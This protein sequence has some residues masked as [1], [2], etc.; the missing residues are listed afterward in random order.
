[1]KRIAIVLAVLLG[2]A[3]PASAA[4]PASGGEIEL[5]IE[6]VGEAQPR[7][8]SVVFEIQ[9]TG[10]SPAAAERGLAAAKADLTRKFG[11][12]GIKSQQITFNDMNPDLYPPP[13]ATV[14]IAPP[15]PPPAVA[16]ST[17]PD[18]VQPVAVAVA[19]PPPVIR[20][21]PP[22]PKLKDS[23]RST[24]TIALDDLGKLDAV[25]TKARDVSRTSYRAPTVIYAQ[26]DPAEA[27]DEAVNKAIS[28]ARAEADRYA[29]AMGYR[30]VRIARVSN[31]KP[32]LNMPDL[33]QFIGTLDRRTGD[34]ERIF[35]TVWAG[36]AIDFVIAPK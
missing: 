2:T 16:A 35:A 10:E 17:K 13:I 14:A 1:M 22:P 3:A 20:P 25:K 36:V 32:A 24:V 4:N 31:A 8:A 7:S 18:K 15:A 21:A 30:V 19:P 12:I 33:F 29:E 23:K 26:R 6:A 11:E 28:Q 34:S 27:R 9:A 5:H